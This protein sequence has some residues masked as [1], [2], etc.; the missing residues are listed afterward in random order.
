MLTI[1]ALFQKD[2]LKTMQVL[3]RNPFFSLHSD[4]KYSF[5]PFVR[6]L[7][8]AA[9]DNIDYFFCDTFDTNDTKYSHYYERYRTMIV[10]TNYVK[11][12]ID[13]ADSI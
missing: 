10:Q 7:K 13:N 1:R 4:E 12:L 6:G 8:S 9:F 2:L 3:E 5:L 11:C